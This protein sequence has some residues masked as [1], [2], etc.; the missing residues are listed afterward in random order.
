MRISLSISCVDFP[1]NCSNINR[2]IIAIKSQ[3]AALASLMLAV[4]IGG[5]HQ[6][7]MVHFSKRELCP[8]LANRPVQPNA[9]SPKGGLMAAATSLIPFDDNSRQVAFD[10]SLL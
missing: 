10:N 7:I 1:Q 3:P 4:T 6:N 2:I 5:G 8:L 9:R